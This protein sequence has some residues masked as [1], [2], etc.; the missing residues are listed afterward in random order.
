MSST[1][2]HPAASRGR[3]TGVSSNSATPPRPGGLSGTHGK[4]CFCPE[5][6][7]AANQV[8]GFIPRRNARIAG[9]SPLLALM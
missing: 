4:T 3:R 9:F 5:S 7:M 6:A 1:I 8:P 2:C